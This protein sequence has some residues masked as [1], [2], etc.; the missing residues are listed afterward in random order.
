MKIKPNLNIAVLIMALV[1]G[2]VAAGVGY[3]YMDNQIADA[4]QE[5]DIYVPA[6]NIPK[7]QQ[8]GI[9]DLSVRTIPAGGVE[10]QA[11]T[12]KSEIVGKYAGQQLY[13]GE[14]IR[15]ERLSSVP[16]LK[17]YGYVSVNVDLAR[18]GGA[19]PGDMVDIY[20][21]GNDT[22]SVTAGATRQPV[23]TDAV[24]ME[25]W[26][27]QGNNIYS[28]SQGGI[29]ETAAKAISGAK[30]PA[31]IKLAV[32]PHQAGGVVDGAVPGLANI[33]LVVK[34]NTGGAKTADGNNIT[35]PEGKNGG[36]EKAGTVTESQDN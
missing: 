1:F 23:A 24:V 14:Q 21:L 17:G 26:D 32:K 16:K 22:A 36:G 2:F 31:V 30:P 34:N 25:I 19:K 11:V 18:S 3:F 13:K 6:K 12:A 28:G 20:K 33:V 4:S 7:Y 35:K 10:P 15:R 29:T 27:G 5:I 9:T 8:I